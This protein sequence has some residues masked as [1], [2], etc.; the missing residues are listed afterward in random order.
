MLRRKIVIVGGPQAGKTEFAKALVRGWNNN[1]GYSF[2]A[3]HHPTV[4]ATYYN[5]QAEPL[6]LGIWDL[7]GQKRYQGLASDYVPDSLHVYLV[8][9]SSALST[10]CKESLREAF[11]FYKTVI[12]CF[13]A[14]KSFPVT[15]VLTKIDDG[16]ELLQEQV[17]NQVKCF[18]KENEK[19]IA[20]V[21]VSSKDMRGIS[22][23][24]DDLKLTASTECKE[25]E[26]KGYIQYMKGILQ[27]YASARIGGGEGAKFFKFIQ[28]PARH[29]TRE[30]QG[31]VNRI[32][33]DLCTPQKIYD[34]VAEATHGC[35]PN[36]TIARIMQDFI[37][38]VGCQ[39]SINTRS[40]EIPLTPVVNAPRF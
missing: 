8:I 1:Q 3:V 16:V 35:K 25:G 40:S 23:L 10:G 18:F 31:I 9:D 2:N 28:H 30:V 11:D 12:E 20:P 39:G 17:V 34:A 4:G 6:Y 27:E 14:S 36:G 26:L 22:G 19:E 32:G 37:G 5:L 15:V 7:G 38:R 13:Q 24:V 29:W 33:V 21:V